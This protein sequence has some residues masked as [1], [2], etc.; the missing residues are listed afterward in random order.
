MKIP[1]GK[2]RFQRRPRDRALEAMLTQGFSG[3]L[4]KEFIWA[5]LP[6]SNISWH[7]PS[8]RRSRNR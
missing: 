8:Q 2:H 7:Y 3:E 4:T 5:D 1:L 6:D